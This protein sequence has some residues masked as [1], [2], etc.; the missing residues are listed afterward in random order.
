M[1]ALRG[2]GAPVAGLADVPCA[3][4]ERR[5]RH[6]QRCCEPV[7]V[8]WGGQPVQLEIRLPA[9]SIQG[10][11][12]CRLELESGRVMRWLCNL[13]GLPARGAVSVEGLA[14]RAVQLTLPAGLPPGYHRLTLDLPGGLCEVLIISAPRRA[15]TLPSGSESRLWGVF[16]PLYA[17]HSGRSWGAGD[18]TDLEGLLHW[19]RRLGGNFTGTLPL[20]AAFLDE[21]FEPSPY[22]P[23]SRLFWNEFYLD[24]ARVEEVKRCPEAQETLNSPAFQGEIESL[25]A[26]GLVDY[27]RGM[28][29]RRSI[30]ERC[31]RFCF[32]EGGRQQA[33]LLRWVAENPAV[34]DYARFRAVAEQRRACWPEWPHRLRQGRIR[35]GDY[36]PEAERYHLYVQWL[37]HRQLQGLSAQAR[38]NGQRLYLDLPLGVHRAGYDVWRRRDSFVLEANCGAPPDTF[39]GRGQDWEFPPLHPERI[40]EDGYRY[41]I[42]CLR[43]HLRHAGILRLDHVMGLH[44]LFW[45]PRGL[46]AREGVYVRYRAEEFYAVLCLESQRHRALIVGENLGTVPACVNI[47]LARHKLYRM[48][49]LP[50][51]FTENRRQVLR[52]VPASAMAGLNT[53]DMPP[54]ADFWLKKSRDTADRAALPVFLHRRKM[55]ATPTSNLKSVFRA[56][57]AYLAASPARIMLVNLEDLWLETAS[58]NMP[59]TA[60]EYPNWRRKAR[61]SLEELI[62]NRDIRQLLNEIHYFRSIQG[63][64]ADL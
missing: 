49:V 54:F 45:V 1:A 34:Q 30:L 14:Y 59:G 4:R 52:P 12:A 41:Y 6:W 28:A 51:E 64:E 2:L 36:A 43:H 35:E 16:I 13:A 48:Y 46:A 33:A 42:A 31:A 38:R 44:R 40:R 21:P 37:A 60:G 7:A 9:G 19:V 61:Y 22:S 39:L 3:V 15:Y 18:L 53:H 24:V 58:Q 57:L 25:R 56:C 17:L 32:A 26:A 47:S 62:D 10:M 23:A 11:A 20:L 29:A 63:Q 50:F 8:S 27:R 5:Q 55:L